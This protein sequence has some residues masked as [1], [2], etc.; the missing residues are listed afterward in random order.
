TIYKSEPICLDISEK[1]GEQDKTSKIRKNDYLNYIFAYFFVE[2]IFKLR[3]I[4]KRKRSLIVET[5]HK[6]KITT[7][8]TRL[9][10]NLFFTPHYMNEETILTIFNDNLSQINLPTPNENRIIILH[11]CDD[12]TASEMEILF[13]RYMRYMFKNRKKYAKIIK[14]IKENPTNELTTDNEPFDH[15]SQKDLN[16]INY[17]D[18]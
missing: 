14:E 4:L 2:K 1:I 5:S 15:H 6:S 18:E 7:F 3:E 9:F 12:Y 8:S 16:D 13:Y 17:F 11:Y 10:S